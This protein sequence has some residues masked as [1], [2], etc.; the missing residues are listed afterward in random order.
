MKF[1]FEMPWPCRINPFVVLPV[2]GT[3]VPIASVE[4]GPRNCPVTG[5]CACRLVPVHGN[6]PF[7]HP[8]T[9]NRGAAARVQRSGKK[10]DACPIVS[11]GGC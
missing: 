7:A 6:T 11:W 2:F 10:L 1:V 8:A 9:Y 4:F 5:S 3:S